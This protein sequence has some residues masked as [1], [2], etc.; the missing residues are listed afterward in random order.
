MLRS[1]EQLVDGFLS[2]LL[3]SCRNCA[4][5]RCPACWRCFPALPGRSQ[6]RT[7]SSSVKHCKAAPTNSSPSKT[8]R[9]NR[10]KELV[11][12]A[13]AAV[14]YPH[15]VATQLHYFALVP[16]CLLNATWV[17]E[18]TLRSLQDPRLLQANQGSNCALRYTM[19]CR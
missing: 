18:L 12:A 5:L 2:K 15:P 16:L 17:V 4:A 9:S 19:F 14:F 6:R 13:A 3:K 1:A 8:G 7:H 10:T 11:K